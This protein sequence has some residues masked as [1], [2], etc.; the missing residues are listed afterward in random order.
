MTL[1][2]MVADRKQRAWV[3]TRGGSNPQGP[4]SRDLSLLKAHSLQRSVASWDPG[5]LNSV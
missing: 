2:L 3:E 1:F 4:V 5:V